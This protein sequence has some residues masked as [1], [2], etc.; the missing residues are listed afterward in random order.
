MSMERKSLA[1]YRMLMV[2]LKKDLKAAFQKGKLAKSLD[3]G[4]TDEVPTV[5]IEMNGA[6]NKIINRHLLA[7]KWILLG[8]YAGKDAVAAA[9]EL[10]LV[11]NLVPG[12]I[13]SAYFDNLDA[14][15]QH[16]VDLIGP[17]P[18][19]MPKELIK[20]SLAEIVARLEKY[21]DAGIT[22]LQIKIESTIE[23][24]T[25]EHNFKNLNE[26]H[27]EAHNLEPT[28][29]DKSVAEAVDQLANTVKL[30]KLMSDISETSKNFE[31]KWETISSANLNMASAAATHQGMM[32]I[33]GAEDDS[34]RVAN[35]EMMDERVCSFCKS[36]SK[37]KNGKQIYYKMD[38]LKPSGYNFR[39]K[40][41]E[42]LPSISPNHHRCRCQTVYIPPG[43][44][45]DQYGGLIKK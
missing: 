5:K 21:I 4:W 18:P 30:N 12:I 6:I 37:D 23:G 38:D 24:V 2:S 31:K 45:V 27:K 29:E 10:G 13:P 26:I 25:D 43:F 17:L 1:A 3:G 40:K 16:Y 9:K 42:W 28:L 20:D 7:M 34:M 14:M 19:E 39:R 44:E 35:I 11:G 8:P 32:E 36:I 41:A 15:E 22:D 33:F